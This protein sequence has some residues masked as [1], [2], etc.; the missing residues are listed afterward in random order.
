MF[1]SIILIIPVLIVYNFVAGRLSYKRQEAGIMTTNSKSKT[2]T[3]GRISI[4]GL[5]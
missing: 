5:L 4:F 3:L 2:R 1:Y